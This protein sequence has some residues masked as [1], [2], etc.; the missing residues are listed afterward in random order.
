MG[1]PFAKIQL[2]APLSPHI[3]RLYAVS[4]DARSFN[5]LLEPAIQLGFDIVPVIPGDELAPGRTEL[6]VV[7]IDRRV[8]E[9]ASALENVIASIGVGMPEAV[10]VLGAGERLTEI[11]DAVD[12]V[13]D[14]DSPYDL[15]RA[16]T[17]ALRLAHERRARRLGNLAGHA[18]LAALDRTPVY[19]TLLDG[20][21][22]R[23]WS[24]EAVGRDFRV[25]VPSLIGAD[26]LTSHRHRRTAATSDAVVRLFRESLAKP[27]I[28][29]ETMTEAL[30]P[31]GTSHRYTMRMTNLLDRSEV[32]AV[33]VMTT[34][35]AEAVI[36]A[37]ALPG[38]IPISFQA[39]IERGP[40]VTFINTIVPAEHIVFVSPQV[41]TLLHLP[42]RALTDPEFNWIERIH[43]VDRER[44]ARESALADGGMT[45]IT[46]EYR[47]LTGLGDYRWLRSVSRLARNERGEAIWIGNLLDIESDRRLRETA[48]RHDAELRALRQLRRLIAQ[49]SE[50][51]AIFD[52][53][54]AL[55]V[56][57][58]SFRMA[59]VY[60]REDDL[61]VLKSAAGS[62]RETDLHPNHRATIDRAA[63][64]GETVVAGPVPGD[65]ASPA[66]GGGRLDA[67]TAEIAVPLVDRDR[68]PG[69]LVVGGTREAP[70]L[71]VDI[72]LIETV[73]EYL[74][75]AT[76]RTRLQ[77]EA[78]EQGLTYQAVVERVREVIFHLAGNLEIRYVN[79]AWSSTLGYDSD[80]Q[81]G[82]SLLDVVHPDE[83]ARIAH[84]FAA[85]DRDEMTEIVT[86]TRLLTR[87]GQT[88]WMELRARPD[89]RVDER[90]EYSGMLVDVT[91]RR[92]SDAALRESNEH[93]RKLAFQDPL[94]GL[95]N[96]LVFHDRLQHALAVGTRRG[97]GVAVLFLDLDGF[98]PVNDLYGH[99]TGDRVLT[100]VGERLGERMRAGDTIARFG[101][102]EFAL[103]LEDLTDASHA[104]TIASELIEAMQAP[105]EV[106]EDSIVVGVSIG[107]TY[108]GGRVI[109]TEDAVAEADAALYDAKKRGR[110]RYEIFD[111]SNAAAEDGQYRSDLRRGIINNEIRIIY[112]P[113]LTLADRRIVA[114][115][116]RIRWD[117]PRYGRL[118]PGHFLR[119]A[120]ASGLLD[121]LSEHVF[122][123]I[124]G[125]LQRWH[126]SGLR[127]P[128]IRFTLSGRQ[129]LD[130]DL[131]RQLTVSRERL[132]LPGGLFGIELSDGTS[133]PERSAIEQ[134][135][136][137][138]QACGI[139]VGLDN[140]TAVNQ[141]LAA[142]LRLPFDFINIEVDQMLSGGWNDRTAAFFRSI[143]TLAGEIDV[144]LVAKM[145][146][147]PEFIPWLEE[148]GIVFAQGDALR[149]ELTANEVVTTLEAQA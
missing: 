89:L 96:R 90:R 144:Q 46:T 59:R 3:P 119:R 30:E 85:L 75:M 86:E 125:D 42:G 58:F 93:F 101:G 22:R 34:E 1:A 135:V 36:E 124:A 5:D 17:R 29:V 40:L 109:T 43:P 76:T 63:R 92:R 121:L 10:I 79:P 72:V 33:V 78:R 25:D 57:S 137:T 56:E 26:Y 20:Q 4:D 12:D 112:H 98:K 66:A 106:F 113:I 14:L 7:L 61:P 148:I 24:S 134:M 50:L 128:Q 62:A 27:G 139:A 130:A 141:S 35:I 19:L 80:R 8:P 60:T 73:A 105:I 102:D 117:H 129:A 37:P 52:A 114:L 91:D 138:L 47:Y 81:I 131:A 133:T 28:P 69:L 147:E 126:A 70:L 97:S 48:E 31:D 87:D 83:R 68:V 118:I 99:A 84:L 120:D 38:D 142:L 143:V 111:H 13:A 100:I 94:T 127:V 55:L 32:G 123:L 140:Y 146:N 41:E 104:M 71:P 115:E 39:M 132:G 110:G 44:I 2:M 15:H 11:P 149:P 9:E 136:E 51:E 6:A 16:L 65:G 67:V 95:P 74:S 18:V 53:A 23:L 88:R 107:V 49:E 116:A 45:E 64:G 82:M 145:V 54:V 103:I 108:L 77:A 122:G 21:G